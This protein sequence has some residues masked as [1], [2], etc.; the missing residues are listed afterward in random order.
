MRRFTG[1]EADNQ[2]LKAESLTSTTREDAV[3]T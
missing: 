3:G 1:A 2:A